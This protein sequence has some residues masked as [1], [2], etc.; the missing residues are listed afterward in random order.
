MSYWNDHGNLLWNPYIKIVPTRFPSHMKKINMFFFYL[1]TPSQVL[2]DQIRLK[3]KIKTEKLLTFL[4]QKVVSK[5]SSNKNMGKGRKNLEKKIMYS[6]LKKSCHKFP[7][8]IEKQK[9]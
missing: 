5:E 3:Q 6:S 7:K 2:D 9:E 1:L 4:E 8:I